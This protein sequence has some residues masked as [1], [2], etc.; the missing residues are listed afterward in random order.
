MRQHFAP[1]ALVIFLLTS[2][3]NRSNKIQNTEIDITRK[4]VHQEQL[5]SFNCSEKPIHGLLCYRVDQNYM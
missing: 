4:N 5:V 2:I 3:N 1:H